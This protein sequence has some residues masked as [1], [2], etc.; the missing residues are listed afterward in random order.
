MKPIDILTMIDPIE[1]KKKELFRKTCQTMKQLKA[2]GKTPQEIEAIVKE[3]EL[4]LNIHLAVM[5]SFTEIC[6]HGR[7]LTKTEKKIGL[8]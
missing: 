5:G 3:I 4:P 2:D 1:Q 7:L 8:R 6:N